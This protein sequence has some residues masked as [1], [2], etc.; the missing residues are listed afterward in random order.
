MR[1]LRCVNGRVDVQMSCEPVFDYGRNDAEWRYTSAGYG[2]AEASGAE[3]DPALR[4]T[5]NMRLG[6]EGRS[7]LAVHQMEEGDRD[8]VALSWSGR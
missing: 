5:T 7:A 1:E 2:E 6:L 4:L 3:G 8:F